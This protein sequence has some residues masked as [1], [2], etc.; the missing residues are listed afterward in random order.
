MALR[1]LVTRFDDR[2][3]D[4]F[5]PLRGRPLPDRICYLASEGADYSRIWHAIGL[6]MALVSP[7]R[8]RHSLRLAVALGVESALVNGVIKNVFGRERPPM[9]EARAYEVRRPRTRSFPS[10]HASSACVTAV[11]LTDAMPGLRPLWWALATTVSASRIHNRMHHAS[12]V[13]AGAAIGTA[14]GVAIR[15]AWPMRSR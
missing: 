12:D 7:S 8:R 9:L 15:R 2:V 10:G 1:Q 13:V 11:L 3:D 6:T 14:L 4:L 5:M